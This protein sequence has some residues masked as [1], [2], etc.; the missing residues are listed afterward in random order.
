MLPFTVHVQLTPSDLR[1]IFLRKTF[2]RPLVLLFSLLAVAYLVIQ[3]IAA[4]TPV[5]P[6]YTYLLPYPIVIFP[7]IMLLA[8]FFRA[9]VTFKGS[10]RLSGGV[11]YT[12]S[13]DELR[14]KAVD[15][16]WAY[17]WSAFRKNEET[18]NYLLLYPSKATFELFPKK[19]FTEEQ[20]NFIRV[21]SGK[22]SI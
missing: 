3:G 9:Y 18:S 1:S 16:E 10:P 4:L 5:D 12:F 7:V 14:G 15:S 13:E 2:R 8:T 22:Y 21:K 17:K 20:L 19:F 6:V 11:D